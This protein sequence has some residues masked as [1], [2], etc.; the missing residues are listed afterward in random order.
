MS[1]VAGTNNWREFSNE[2]ADPHNLGS[3]S[4]GDITLPAG[5]YQCRISVPAFR[6]ETHQARL[7][8]SG[9]VNLLFGT[10]GFS[11][12]STEGAQDR[13]DIMGQF[14]L[15]ATTTLRV[16]HFCTLAR[17]K[18][19]LGRFLAALQLERRQPDRFCHRRVLEDPM[20]HVTRPS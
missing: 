6:I 15:G 2:L 17:A 5:T 14:E 7:R 10:I 1:S 11:D 18:R 16:P 4:A 12:A 8:T 3:V 19:R 13:S 9:G 20:S